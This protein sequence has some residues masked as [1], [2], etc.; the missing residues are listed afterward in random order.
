MRPPRP[1]RPHWG[2]SEQ[3]EFF[4]SDYVFPGASGTARSKEGAEAKGGTLEKMAV[5]R[6]LSRLTERTLET[7]GRKLRPHDLRR[8][9][10]TLLSRIG[11]APHVAELCLN[12]QEKETM[13]RVYDGHDYTAEMADAWD[14]AG[15]HIQAIREGSA[16]VVSIATLRA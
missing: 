7:G 3:K 1:W 6:A 15:A 13:R 16:Q 10:R 2:E 12:H 8:T 4:R 11:V 14:R 5:A 9:F